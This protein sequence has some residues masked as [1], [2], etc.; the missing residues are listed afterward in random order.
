MRDQQ[1]HPPRTSSRGTIGS[2]LCT[3]VPPLLPWPLPPWGARLLRLGSVITILRG[4][5]ECDS[6]FFAAIRIAAPPSNPMTISE[7]LTPS[8]GRPH[9]VYRDPRREFR[10]DRQGSGGSPPMRSI[11]ASK[12][13]AAR[14]T[15]QRYA[16]L[17]P[18]GLR[19]RSSAARSPAGTYC[20]PRPEGASPTPCRCH[21][22]GARRG[23]RVPSPSSHA[24]SS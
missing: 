19:A 12:V 16:A 15:W 4:A 18:F 7:F 13:I 14:I 2:T 3:I 21:S 23:W 8:V 6:T 17:P 20:A 11:W 9:P 24:R 10:I 1:V 5:S 22:C